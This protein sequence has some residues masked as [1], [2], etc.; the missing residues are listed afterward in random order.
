MGTQLSSQCYQKNSL[1]HTF[2]RGCVSVPVW[3]AISYN[4]KWPLV[5]LKPT[6]KHGTVRTQ[7][8]EKCARTLEFPFSATRGENTANPAPS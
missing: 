4:W 8:E 3:G 2:N 6:G 7:I 5:F 1:Q